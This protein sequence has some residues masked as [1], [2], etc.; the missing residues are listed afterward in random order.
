MKDMVVQSECA[1]A[2]RPE[3]DSQDKKKSNSEGWDDA[4]KFKGNGFLYSPEAYAVEQELKSSYEDGI[5]EIMNCPL[6][7]NS[8]ETLGCT[9]D[10]VFLANCQGQDAKADNS[11]VVDVPCVNRV[12]TQR[13]QQ[14]V[15]STYGIAIL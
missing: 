15:S 8:Q 12:S 13:I 11:K 9:Y 1:G 3:K 4:K 5:Y 2:E 6:A 7:Q 10:V 14:K